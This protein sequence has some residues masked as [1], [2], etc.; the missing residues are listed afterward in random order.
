VSEPEIITE[1]D[2]RGK[3]GS[4]EEIRAAGGWARSFDGL[5]ELPVGDL[6]AVRPGL[7]HRGE[8]GRL[9]LRS[10]CIHCPKDQPTEILLPLEG[11]YADPVDDPRRPLAKEIVVRRGWLSLFAL[12]IAQR[13]ACDP[14][15]ERIE[16]R[17]AA[18]ASKEATSGR[19]E[20]ARIPAGL[21]AKVSKD[22][23]WDGLIAEGRSPDE[24][25]HRSRAI[26][27]AREWAGKKRPDRGLLIWGPPGAGKTHLVATLALERLKHSPIVWV[28]VG[29]LM[30]ELEGAWNDD[31]RKRALKVLT[32]T[33]PAVLDDLDKFNPTDSKR[34]QIFT[35]LD[36]REQA[37][38]PLIVTTNK[39][40]SEL[41]SIMGDVIVSRLLG[42]CNVLEYPGPDRRLSMETG[43]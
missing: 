8:D 11:L 21:V 34:G 10:W 22:G 4:P 33:T 42:M 27:L 3:R 15:C 40:P 23:L 28:S 13:M 7:F 31:D 19:A 29:V 20:K 30:A 37:R 6:A 5:G 26:E 18:R 9:F 1:R 12:K 35:A 25:K 36:K 43:S 38:T 41:R 17:E 24:T 14:C 16:A 2:V 32:S 39:K